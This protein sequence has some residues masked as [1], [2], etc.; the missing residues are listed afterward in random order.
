M[1]E[2]AR[3]VENLTP[4]THFEITAPNKKVTL[5]NLLKIIEE[6]QNVVNL[7]S[8]Y[9]M[10]IPLL[11]KA[12]PQ[13]P[14]AVK[15]S[16]S[17]TFSDDLKK[18]KDDMKT[19]IQSRP[20]VFDIAE[21]SNDGENSTFKKKRMRSESEGDDSFDSKVHMTEKRQIQRNPKGTDLKKN[22][23]KVVEFKRKVGMITCMKEALKFE[24]EIK[25]GGVELAK[26]L[27]GLR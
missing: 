23:E 20:I 4:L 19:E 10:I 26:D 25:T 17:D 6:L 3:S 11:A 2:L 7:Q 18:L 27:V 9:L 24:K 16:L 13:M 22:L 12:L 14:E 8:A 21:M 15:T 5:A 1:T